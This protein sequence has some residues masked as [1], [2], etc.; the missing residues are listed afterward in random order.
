[1]HKIPSIHRKILRTKLT[2][3]RRRKKQRKNYSREA[4]KNYKEM[5]TNLSEIYYNTKMHGNH[6]E[7]KK[8]L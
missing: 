8:G 5:Q 3:K 7:T 6:R 4:T 2:A 1:M